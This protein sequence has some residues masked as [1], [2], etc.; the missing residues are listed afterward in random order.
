MKP[1]YVNTN[2]LPSGTTDEYW[3]YAEREQGSYPPSSSNSGKWMIFVPIEQV[4]KVWNLVQN[5]TVTGQ[6][7]RSAKVATM[8]H[9][10]N[11]TAPDRKVICVYTYDW[12]DVVDVQ[13]VR[14][15]LRLIGIQ[16]K[17]PYKADADTRAGKYA[18]R[19]H[20]RISKYYE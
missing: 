13:R 14:Q 12:T 1:K 4:D 10:P 11:A 7:G 9:N 3:I 19:G 20:Q 2:V 16:Q 18:S 15:Q 17:I 5:A 8:K 6:L